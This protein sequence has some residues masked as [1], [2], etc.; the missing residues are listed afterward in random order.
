MKFLQKHLQF[1][2]AQLTT[3]ENKLVFFEK[4]KGREDA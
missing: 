1:L 4:P 2:K 3:I